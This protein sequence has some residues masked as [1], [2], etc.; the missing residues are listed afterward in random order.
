[1]KKDKAGP[2]K[3]LLLFDISATQPSAY[4]EIQLGRA[5]IFKCKRR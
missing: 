2:L 5:K 4:G 3:S 1:M